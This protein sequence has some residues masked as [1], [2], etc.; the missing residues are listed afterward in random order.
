MAEALR[1]RSP[2]GPPGSSSTPADRHPRGVGGCPWSAARVLAAAVLVA[3][4]R[5]AA[6]VNVSNA[7]SSHAV[8]QRDA[9]VTV[10]GWTTPGAVVTSSCTPETA[11]ANATSSPAGADGVWRV[12]L[13]PMPASSAP[14]T[15]TLTGPGGDAVSL[16]DLLVGDV[17]LCSGQSNMGLPVSVLWNVTD[18]VREAGSRPALRL[19]AASGNDGSATPRPQFNTDGLVPWQAPLGNNASAPSNAT[20]M[21]Y[22]AACYLFG[23]TLF[24]YLGGAVPVGLV[25]S[26]HGGSS[27]LAWQSPASVYT[28]VS[29]GGGG[30]GQEGRGS[31][32]GGEVG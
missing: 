29:G 12:V 23:A 30:G 9:P 17:F 10:W 16:V 22:S 32:E 1:A 7:L 24:D 26:A 25:L 14:F 2:P 27:I 15:L 8:L 5:A 18:V 20:L 19:F 13:P 28:C 3:A 6:A 4:P 11:C 31:G 21:G